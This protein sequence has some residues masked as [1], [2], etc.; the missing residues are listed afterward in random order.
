MTR[1]NIINTYNT[2]RCLV[3]VHQYLKVQTI[4]Y[5]AFIQSTIDV[6][7]IGKPVADKHVLQTVLNLTKS[8]KLGWTF[9]NESTTNSVCSCTNAST[10]KLLGT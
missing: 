3:V 5:V 9:L 10:T 7:L 6:L 1:R 4:A 8:N 2:A